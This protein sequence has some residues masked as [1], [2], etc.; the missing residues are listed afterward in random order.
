MSS[1][2]KIIDH[3]SDVTEYRAPAS[4]G[5]GFWTWLVILS[6]AAVTSPVSE[7]APLR[8]GATRFRAYLSSY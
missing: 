1:D 5:W 8:R 4:S 7:E 3:S 6:T 2:L